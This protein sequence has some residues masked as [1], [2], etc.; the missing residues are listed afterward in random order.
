MIPGCI[1]KHFWFVL[2]I[3]IDFLE[4]SEVFVLVR[5]VLLHGYLL[6]AKLKLLH[7]VLWIFHLQVT[8]LLLNVETRGSLTQWWLYLVNLLSLCAIGLSSWIIFIWLVIHQFMLLNL[9]KIIHH[10]VP[11]W[12]GMHAVWFFTVDI[13]ILVLEIIELV[14]SIE[15]IWNLPVG[16]HHIE[17]HQIIINYVLVFMENTGMA[18][19]WRLGWWTWVVPRGAWAGRTR[20]PLWWWRVA[21]AYI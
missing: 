2:P 21:L 6:V 15:R 13:A 11:I 19:F 5:S 9:F 7:L 12:V 8:L 20:W 3:E 17:V 14:L 18:A 16:M 4:D 10:V 1:N